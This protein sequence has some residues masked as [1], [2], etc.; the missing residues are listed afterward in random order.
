MHTQSNV[1]IR[2]TGKPWR[3]GPQ[4]TRA[5]AGIAG[6]GRCLPLK[7]NAARIRLEK[8]EEILAIRPRSTST[9]ISGRDITEEL[10][11]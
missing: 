8:V 5:V 7:G 4:L 9:I 1:I 2:P 6:G 11:Y 10:Y 3:L